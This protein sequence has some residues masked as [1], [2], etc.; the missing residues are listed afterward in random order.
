MNKEMITLGEARN[1]LILFI[2]GS[3]MILGAAG[4][5]KNDAWIAILIAIGMAVPVVL[6]SARLLALYPGQNLFDICQN[7]FGRLLGKV[8]ILLYVWYAVHLAA[9][10]LRNFGEFMDAQAM[11]ETPM[12]VPMLFV[13]AL[14]AG[15]VLAGIETMGRSAR[16]LFNVGM[17]TILIV[18]LLTIGRME[19]DNLL[20]VLDRGWGPVWKGAIS[21]F[22]F[23]FAEIILFTA[24]F[25]CIKGQKSLL[26]VYILGLLIGGGLVLFISIRNI[27]VLGVY[28][29][30][31]VYFPSYAAVGRI[32]VGDFIQRIE[33]TVAI[34]FVIGVFIKISVCLFA[35]SKGIAKLFGLSSYRSVVIQTGLLVT[36]LAVIL[37]GNIMEME[38]FAREIYFFYAFPFQVILPAIILLFTEIKARSARRAKSG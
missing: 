9:L 32:T 28:T 11:P 26:N 29:M 25:S 6:I 7:V 24:V 4:Q 19:F 16:L 23:P 22:S 18:L 17:V 13:S 1:I 12:I 35:A 2:M 8:L 10:V 38:Y 27:A 21:A 5:A 36:Y 31:N 33:G 34:V 15:V 20:P 30:S 37:Y 3:T 14:S